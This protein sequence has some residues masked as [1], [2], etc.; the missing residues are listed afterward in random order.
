MD[1]WH[2]NQLAR[3]PY[4]HPRESW[5]FVCNHVSFI[6]GEKQE[7]ANEWASQG[8]ALIDTMLLPQK[9]KS[10]FLVI[11]LKVLARRKSSL[12]TGRNQASK[13]QQRE[14]SKIRKINIY[15]I[16]ATF[17]SSIQLINSIIPLFTFYY[18]FSSVGC[19][20]ERRWFCVRRKFV[21]IHCA[22]YCSIV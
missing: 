7:E 10:L 11:I 8:L 18:F 19:T 9:S 5:G 21:L 20:C 15:S 1:V 12:L 6:C 4:H 22:A 3:N 16:K 14:F 2:V 17:S 13:E